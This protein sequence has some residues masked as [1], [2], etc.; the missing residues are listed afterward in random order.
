MTRDIKEHIEQCQECH[1]TKPVTKPIRAPL[2]PLERPPSPNHRIHIDL[3][4]PLSTTGSGKKHIMVI[5]DAFT[6]YV[7]LVALKSKEAGEV[8]LAKLSQEQVS[9][10]QRMKVLLR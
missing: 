6:K 4:G 10:G 3:F 2:K 7:E 9:S 5:T 1:R 8:A